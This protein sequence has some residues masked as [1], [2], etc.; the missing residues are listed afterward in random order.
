M[1]DNLYVE[2]SVHNCSSCDF[3]LTTQ[4]IADVKMS[5]PRPKRR[6]LQILRSR[7]LIRPRKVPQMSATRSPRTSSHVLP[8]C[9]SHL[10]RL[11]TEANSQSVAAGDKSISQQASDTTSN[12]LGG[13]PG[14]KPLI[15]QVQDAATGA[16]NTV[17]KA[18][19]GM[20]PRLK[21][22]SVR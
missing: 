17:T 20:S 14:E 7:I 16:Y 15:E 6:S 8:P 18:A 2:R 1:S 21:I 12:A 22:S 3:Q 11:K 19:T 4:L 5:P 10:L 13:K 9:L